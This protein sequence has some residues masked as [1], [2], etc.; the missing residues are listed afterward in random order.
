MFK[1][2]TLH[3]ERAYRK[4]NP[5][6]RALDQTVARILDKKAKLKKSE[7]VRNPFSPRS[8]RK[9]TN[10]TAFASVCD[11]VTSFSI[12]LNMSLHFK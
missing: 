5:H 8:E 3:K 12:L 10:L 1:I 2:N 9:I 4:L 11:A 7:D 6:V